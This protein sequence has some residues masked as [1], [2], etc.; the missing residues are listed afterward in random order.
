MHC[1]SLE[2]DINTLL[3]IIPGLCLYL[4]VFTLKIN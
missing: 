1:A 3:Y 4:Q 2:V